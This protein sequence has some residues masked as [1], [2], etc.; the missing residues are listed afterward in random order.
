MLLAMA[1][2]A[3]A[4]G[5]SGTIY[6]KAVLAP[7]AITITG[8]GTDPG[9]PLTYEGMLGT[10]VWEKFGA[11]VTV[12]NS[13]TQ[14][15]DLKLDVDQLPHSGDGTWN[16]SARSD[17]DTGI[18]SF[19]SERAGGSE[20]LPTSDPWYSTYS[21]LEHGLAAGD[22]DEFGSAFDFPT[23]SSS[24]SDHYMSATISAVAPIN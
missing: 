10:E 1:V 21:T 22:S 24:S 15:T 16:L 6:G 14:V 5:T 12:Q 20:V 9:S 18:W 3:F 2:P 4:D 17:A 13:G 7:Y 8:G 11:E 19:Y 23:S